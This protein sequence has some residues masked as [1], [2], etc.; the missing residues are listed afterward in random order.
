MKHYRLERTTEPERPSLLFEI[1]MQLQDVRSGYRVVEFRFFKAEWL[2]EKDLGWTRDMVCE[3]HREILVEVDP[4]SDLSWPEFSDEKMIQYLVQYYRPQIWRNHLIGMYS[5]EGETKEELISRC[6][7]ALFEEQSQE[8]KK[9]REVF[10]HCFL[11]LEQEIFRNV[12]QE[13]WDDDWKNLILMRIRDLISREGQDL[14][15]WSRGDQCPPADK[16][17]SKGTLRVDPSVQEKLDDLADVFISRYHQIDQEYEEKANQIEPYE[18]P[19]S[20]SQIDIISRGII[21]H[22][23]RQDERR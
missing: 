5:H 18:V 17:A 9:F 4:P 10:L 13:G 8:L 19:V 22:F 11:E 23:D 14:S 7:E 1:N 16:K 2:E 6:R 12:P 21:W 20:Y 15:R 3:I